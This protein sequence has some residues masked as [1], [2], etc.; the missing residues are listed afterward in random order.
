M[1]NE[2]ESCRR[3]STLL[4][5]FDVEKLATELIVKNV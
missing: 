1:Q 2:A 4:V 5:D 3:V